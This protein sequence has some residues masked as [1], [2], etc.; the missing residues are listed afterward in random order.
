[1]SGDSF[2]Q[3]VNEEIRQERARALWGRYGPIALG[4]VIA[5][6]VLV[7]VYQIYSSHQNKASEQG[8]DLLLQ[9]IELEKIGNVDGALKIL[10]QIKEKN[11]GVYNFMARV[12]EANIAYQK[13]S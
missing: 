8:G 1:M 4:V 5:L 11:L 12:H 7:A 3:E 13:K 2:I 6:I 10:Q 9:A